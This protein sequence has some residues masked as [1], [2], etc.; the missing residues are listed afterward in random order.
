M[1]IL[2]S[3]GWYFPESTGGSEVYLS[4][5]VRELHE[6]GVQNTIVAP[7][8][9]SSSRQYLFEGTEVFR[10]PVLPERSPDQISGKT[11]HGGFEQFRAL[12]S[13]DNFDL[14]HQHSWTYGCGLHHLQAAK[15]AGL[16]TVL[17]IHV[18]AP[19]C[20][21]GTML[22]HGSDVCD[23]RIEVGKCSECWFESKNVGPVS[24]KMI[25]RLPV[26]IA[27]S[28][29][30]F[31]RVGTALATP[32]IVQ[33]HLDTLLKAAEQADSIVAVCQWLRDA[34]LINGI[35]SG[36]VLLSR[37]GLRQAGSEA[38]KRD[39]GDVFKVGFLGR[40]DPVKGAH[41]LMEAVASLPAECPLLLEM[42]M[43]WS[44]NPQWQTYQHQLRKT[45][46]SDN[47]IH[48]QDA[49]GPDEVHNFLA[50]IDILAVP[51]QL[52]ETGPLVVL[53]AMAA[54]VPVLGADIGGIAELVSHDVNGLLLP[55]D[56]VQ[57]WSATLQK[58]A[59][60]PAEIQRLTAGVN[61]SVRSMATVASEMC[62]LYSNLL[63]KQ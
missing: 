8:D 3:I 61:R 48:L 51:S 42:H 27:G 40:A 28:L 21:R 29:R 22:R 24:R 56:Q 57:P 44:D 55:Y 52:L 5:L 14:Y 46:A 10:Y 39:F 1:K 9:G 18:P 4:Q 25:A 53:E 63:A 2:Q 26:P 62:D 47:R 23:G 16:P 36:K 58:L 31:G 59:E 41:L 37:Q 60:N 7:V 30:R 19:V 13:R 33:H 49:I 38:V 32:A 50:G 20:L 17:T 12:L 45:A 6:C 15:Q 54:G 34:L 11:P 43:V 35:S